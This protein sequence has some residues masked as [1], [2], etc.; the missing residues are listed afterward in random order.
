VIMGSG[1]QPPLSLWGVPVPW[2]CAGARVRGRHSVDVGFPALHPAALRCC[3][4]T[5]WS[6]HRVSEGSPGCVHLSADSGG[7]G[8]GEGGGG[9]A[10]G[11]GGRGEGRGVPGREWGSPHG[12]CCHHRRTSQ[13]GQGQGAQQGQGGQAGGGIG[14]LVSGAPLSGLLSRR[15]SS[16]GGHSAAEE[17]GGKAFDRR[18]CAACLTSCPSL[19][20]SCPIGTA[21]L[22]STKHNRT[23]WALLALI[24]TAAVH[25]TVHYSLIP[26]LSLFTQLL[27]QGISGG[28]L[29]RSSRACRRRSTRGRA[30][31]TVRTRARPWHRR[32][33][34]GCGGC[35]RGCARWRA[36]P[37]TKC[38]RTS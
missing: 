24:G 27:W 28:V 8:E 5:R 21:A 10:G 35:W 13:Q 38:A 2:G 7:R 22:H 33:R 36:S 17:G 26:T 14:G 37:S 30:C 19:G 34:W 23:H 15:R 4:T 31:T 32:T 16:A 3:T 18:G 12:A 20:S 6:P 29:P 9:A 11:G 1:Q 25:S